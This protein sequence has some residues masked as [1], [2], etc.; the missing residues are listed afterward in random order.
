MGILLGALVLA[1]P[2]AAQ[3]VESV[4]L[5]PGGGDGYYVPNGGVAR[6]EVAAV[7]NLRG[8]RPV[9]IGAR[10]EVKRRF[11]GEQVAVF[12]ETRDLV[13]RGRRDGSGADRWYLPGFT[14]QVACSRDGET[15]RVEGR[16]V[17]KSPADLIIQIGVATPGE[18]GRLELRSD[19][20][21][22]SRKTRIVC[23]RYAPLP[24]A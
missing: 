15:V 21:A 10:L 23:G 12:E 1:G 7:A 18:E 19:S 14:W 13:R 11:F 6:L 5:A 22:E 2:A 20:I 17:G 8:R 16:S 3:E 9:A 24:E 4:F